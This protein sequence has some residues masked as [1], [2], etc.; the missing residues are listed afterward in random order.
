MEHVSA[1]TKC[2]YLCRKWSCASHWTVHVRCSAKFCDRSSLFGRSKKWTAGSDLHR[3]KQRPLQVSTGALINW[4]VLPLSFIAILKERSKFM[5]CAVLLS[6]FR[7]TIWRSS[8]LRLCMDWS[9]SIWP[10]CFVFICVQRLKFWQNSSSQKSPFFFTNT[11][12][13]HV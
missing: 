3:E 7:V 12:N 8:Q 13:T 5:L 2:T 9:E 6:L 10:Q 4:R 1:L 11:V